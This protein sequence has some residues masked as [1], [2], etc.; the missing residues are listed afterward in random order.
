MMLGTYE[1]CPEHYSINQQIDIISDFA[2]NC[3]IKTYPK[4][5]LI[6]YINQMRPKTELIH[7]VYTA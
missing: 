1:F 4:L 7:T 6:L 3:T 2:S 5:V